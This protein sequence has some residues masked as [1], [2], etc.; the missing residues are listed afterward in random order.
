MN[1]DE[2]I[3]AAGFF[4]GE[5]HT[6]YQVQI[7]STRIRGIRTQIGQ[8]LNNREVLE[9]FQAAVG[10]GKICKISG[11]G[12]NNQYYAYYTSSFETSQAVIAML[13]K[14]LSSSKKAQAKKALLGYLNHDSRKVVHEV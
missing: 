7:K 13:W 4:D 9:R 2:I 10:I 6:V 14:F 12:L 3:W 5:G 1:R 8:A 11:K